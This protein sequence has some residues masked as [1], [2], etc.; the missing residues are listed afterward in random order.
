LTGQNIQETF[1]FLAD[2]L[3]EVNN[4][5][6]AMPFAKTNGIIDLDD[7]DETPKEVSTVS[8]S[9]DSVSS[10][11]VSSD[12]VSRDEF[13]ELQDRIHTIEERLNTIQTIIKKIVEKIQE[14]E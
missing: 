8:V 12:S 9:S 7:Y 6:D 4:I 13:T 2:K 5:K 3:L 14:E 11:S 1:E 10:D